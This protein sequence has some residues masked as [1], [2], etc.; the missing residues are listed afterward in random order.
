[1][2]YDVYKIVGENT[3]LGKAPP[4]LI[5]VGENTILALS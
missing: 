1:M 2:V 5:I 3:I 4:Q